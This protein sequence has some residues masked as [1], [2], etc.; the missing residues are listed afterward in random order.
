MIK[1]FFLVSALLLGVAMVGAQDKSTHH[2]AM[3]AE[4][5]VN[6]HASAPHHVK[7]R[8]KV[9]PKPKHRD[10]STHHAAVHAEHWLDHHMSAPHKTKG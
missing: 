3:H 9:K 5:W 7:H 8:H 10:R 1:T 6:H 4:H 2:A